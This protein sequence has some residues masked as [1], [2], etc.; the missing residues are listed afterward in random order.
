MRTD[1]GYIGFKNLGL[2]TQTNLAVQAIGAIVSFRITKGVIRLPKI[3]LWP[4]NTLSAN[5]I[6]T[7]HHSRIKK[8]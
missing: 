8:M 6:N 5:T 7:L 2:K 4:C 1:L 3:P